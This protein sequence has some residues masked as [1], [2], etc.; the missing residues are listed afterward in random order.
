[1][2]VSSVD[3]SFTYQSNVDKIIVPSMYKVTDGLDKS[4]G[5]P[6]QILKISDQILNNINTETDPVNLELSFNSY[7]EYLSL[8]DDA[9]KELNS[10]DEEEYYNRVFRHDPTNIKFSSSTHAVFK[11]ENNK[12]LPGYG[13]S[14]AG[15]SF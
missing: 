6:K 3:G 1:M 12:C 5:C 7:G 11:F 8:G 13:N 14:I 2:K 10:K 15:T 4:K 9:F